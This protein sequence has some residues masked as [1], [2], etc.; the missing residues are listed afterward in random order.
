MVKDYLDLLKGSVVPDDAQVDHLL[1]SREPTSAARTTVTMRCLPLSVFAAEYDRA[2]RIIDE[3]GFAVPGSPRPGADEPA[4]P[5]LNAA[6]SPHY[7]WGLRHF[8]EDDQWLLA[9]DEQALGV[10]EDLDAPYDE[11]ILEDPHGFVDLDVPSQL[12]EFDDGMQAHASAPDAADVGLHVPFEAVDAHSE[13]GCCD[14][15][16]QRDGVDGDAE[17]GHGSTRVGGGFT[18]EF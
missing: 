6:Q 9:G 13:R 8:S 10:I 12:A 16:G 4:A 11:Q 15:L 7:R 14:R 1:V 3:R 2:F 17:V 5:F 18:D